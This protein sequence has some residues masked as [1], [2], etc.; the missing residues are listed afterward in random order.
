MLH[1]LSSLF[2]LQVLLLSACTCS[3]YFA[4]PLGMRVVGEM[5]RRV[6]TK[7]EGR[8]ET[9][10][11]PVGL[12]QD[13]P[14][15]QVLCFSSSLNYLGNSISDE[16]FLSCFSDNKTT[17]KWKK[18]ATWW[19]WTHSSQTFWS[20]RIDNITLCD[21]T[22]LPHHQPENCAQADHK[23]WDPLHHLAFKNVLLKPIKKFRCFE[24]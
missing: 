11:D 17:T 6:E 1:R 14:S 15:P 3:K 21:S 2:P 10:P 16:H 22:Q 8:V 13:R 9:K 5:E 18:L 19:S 20:L 23:P 7:V 12:S 4:G 24:N